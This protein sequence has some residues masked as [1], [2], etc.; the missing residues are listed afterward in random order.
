MWVL[1][2]FLYAWPQV[3]AA[4]ASLTCWSCERC[5]VR[6]Y[7]GGA[8][9]Q[10]HASPVAPSSNQL[11]AWLISSVVQTPPI[12]QSPS[13]CISYVRPAAADVAAKGPAKVFD[14]MRRDLNRRRERCVRLDPAPQSS[15]PSAPGAC[16]A[17]RMCLEAGGA[18]REVGVVGSTRASGRTLR[19]PC[20]VRCPLTKSSKPAYLPTP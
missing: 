19:A 2:G 12:P 13:L 18:S 8:L 4:L 9:L 1:L 10:G 17:S 5:C 3:G 16:F 11:H 6:L 15:D 14:S 20:L 7:S